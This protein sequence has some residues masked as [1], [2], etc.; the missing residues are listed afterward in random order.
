MMTQA[1][2]QAHTHQKTRTH[3]LAVAAM[4]TAVAFILQFI[5][6]SIPMLIPSF[7]KL[8]L[9]D[10]PAL[11]GTFSLGPVY[12]AAIQLAKN[13]LHLPFGSSAGAGEL[14]NFILG[15]VFVVTAGLIYRHH[16]SRKSALIGSFIGAAAM[17]VVSL[18][19]NY[20]FVYPAYVVLYHLPL[21]A[22]IGM[23]QQLLGG[24]A[25][26]PTGN[27]LLNCLMVFN[28]PFTLCKG[29]LNV[30]LCFLIYKPLSPLLHR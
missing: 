25:Q 27:A 16:K 7:V 5:E 18:P 20:F 15:S 4:L 9:S 8:D 22:I 21:E 13:L 11:L 26:A 30:A 17:A 2:A 24:I 6:F 28:L 19:I 10:L 3:K 1:Q 14:C 12:G 29:L 23:Y